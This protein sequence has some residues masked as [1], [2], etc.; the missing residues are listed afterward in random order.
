MNTGGPSVVNTRVVT[1]RERTLCSVKIAS[2]H[3]A[4]DKYAHLLV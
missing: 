2:S 1:H 3:L 4:V